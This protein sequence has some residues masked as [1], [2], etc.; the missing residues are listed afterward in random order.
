MANDDNPLL[1]QENRTGLSTFLSFVLQQE[2]IGPDPSLTTIETDRINEDNL[3]P[4][5]FNLSSLDLSSNAINLLAKG[6]KFTPTPQRI[7]EVQLR[8]D[9]LNLSGKVKKKFAFFNNPVNGVKTPIEFQLTKNKSTKAPPVPKDPAIK[10]LCGLIEGISTAHK[11]KPKKNM[12]DGMY[13]ALH[14]LTLEDVC[15][16]AADKGSGVVIMNKAY[17]V[18]SME[19][20]LSDKNTYEEVTMDCTTLVDKV[21]KFAKKWSHILTKDETAAITRQQADISEIYGLP[22]IHKSRTLLEAASNANS[23]I[24]NSFEPPDVKFRPIVSCRNC[25]TA[26]LCEA[27]NSFLQPLAARV[28]YRLTDTWDFLRSCPEK[29]EQGTFIVTADISSLYT[30]IT[31]E[32]GL[33]AISHYWDLYSDTLFPKRFTKDFVLELFK[34]CQENLYFVFN[35]KVIRQKSGTGMGKIYAP[36]LADIK[37]GKDEMSLEN[38]IIDAIPS[39]PGMMFLSSYKRY[40]DD[41][42]FRMHLQYKKELELIQTKMN[43][44]DPNITYIFEPGIDF[45]TGTTKDVPYLDVSLHINE[46]GTLDTDIYAKDTDTFNYLP[47]QSSH[48]RH[49]ARNIPFALARRIKGIVSNPDRVQ[50]RMA[51]MTARLTEGLPIKPYKGCY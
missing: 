47:F 27:L 28:K 11:D 50:L 25:P 19:H 44:I 14:Q 9:I 30:N 48:P 36:A 43:E 34:F 22:K 45:D 15:I 18:S 35:G 13:E 49:V 31:T 29:V 8:A 2:S 33:A 41:V 26:K 42:I 7:D 20:M 39:E 40:L 12:A 38:W 46:D 3:T 17:Y 23:I 24:I 4:T 51:D 32:S 1:P 16:K 5:I 21:E 10:T 6:L 37:V